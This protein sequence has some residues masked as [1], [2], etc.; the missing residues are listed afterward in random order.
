MAWLSLEA[1]FVSS[2]TLLTAQMEILARRRHPFLGCLAIITAVP[3]VLLLLYQAQQRFSVS[4]RSPMTLHLVIRD[5][6]GNPLS[7]ARVVTREET[8]FYLVP[9]PFVTP[10]WY[11]GPAPKLT[12]SDSSGRVAIS[13]R[14]ELIV[15]EAVHRRDGQQTR[16]S[17]LR[18]H[19]PAPG[20]IH[21][22]G[23]LTVLY[24]FYPTGSDPY[25]KD[26]D[27]RLLAR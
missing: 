19:P 1:L 17:Y 16:F 2:H 27:I 25:R 6:D 15:L 23:R 18:T 9:I 3:F 13:F 4:S 8:Q 14:H 11:S 5:S 26:Y 7:G 21:K 10:T 24:G 22:P 12:E 20:A